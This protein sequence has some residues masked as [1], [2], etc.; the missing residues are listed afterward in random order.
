MTV[1]QEVFSLLRF[2][3]VREIYLSITA[4]SVINWEKHFNWIQSQIF[5]I[6]T[7]HEKL[8]CLLFILLRLFSFAW[9]QIS[10]YFGKLSW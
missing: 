1:S 10:V 3:G 6:L 9:I 5:G 8:L 4:N 7:N 2:D